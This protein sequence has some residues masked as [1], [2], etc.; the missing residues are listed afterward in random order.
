M[1][2]RVHRQLTLKTQKKE[3]RKKIEICYYI[4]H[5][6]TRSS[7]SFE[8]ERSHHSTELNERHFSTNSQD[9]MYHSSSRKQL[10][11][12]ETQTLTFIRTLL[13]FFSLSFKINKA[14]M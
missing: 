6:I 4:S 12:T 3:N 13:I 11:R 8:K 14:V 2:V 10:H 1:Y 5:V 7:S 9:T